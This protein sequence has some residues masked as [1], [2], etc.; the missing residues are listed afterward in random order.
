MKMASFLSNLVLFMVVFLFMEAEGE[1]H[2]EDEV[3]ADIERLF[4]FNDAG[5][6]NGAVSCDV[7]EGTMSSVNGMVG[8]SQSEEKIGPALHSVCFTL[9]KSFMGECKILTNNYQTQIIDMWIKGIK[10]SKICTLLVI[11][12]V[13]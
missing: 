5:P 6:R 11:C 12:L 1:F 2:Q 8:P 10:P 13:H 7:C 4:Q 3:M 9:T